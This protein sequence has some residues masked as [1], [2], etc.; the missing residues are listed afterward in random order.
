MT[1]I[2]CLKRFFSL[3]LSVLTADI[4][5]NTSIAPIVKFWLKTSLLWQLLLSSA[6]LQ[7]MSHS[8]LYISTRKVF[9]HVLPISPILPYITIYYQYYH[10]L[11][12][13]PILPYNT[14]ITIYGLVRSLHNT[15]PHLSFHL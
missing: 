9:Y 13:L 1:S 15:H 4:P 7:Q 12:I 14:N 2:C 6:T 8:V 3:R 11:P 10:I 5:P